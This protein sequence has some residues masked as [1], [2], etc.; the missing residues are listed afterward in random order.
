VA[1][2][3][4][5]LVAKRRDAPYRPGRPTTDWVVV[6]AVHVSPTPGRG[7]W[8]PMDALQLLQQDH[9]QVRALI[10]RFEQGDGDKKAAVTEIIAL[11]KVHNAIEE[12]IFYPAVRKEVEGAADAVAEGYEEH[13][14]AAKEAGEIESF[15]GDDEKW[16][17]KATV[18][19]ELFQHHAEEEEK[20]MFAKVREGMDASRRADLGR[21]MARRK[22]ALTLGALDKASLEKLAREHEI[23]GRS[24]MTK[25]ELAE[26]LADVDE[27]LTVG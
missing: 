11:L 7:S 23:A 6:P 9:D 21:E 5:G 16:E 18:L 26:A 10:E 24:N 20:E 2:G 1:N 25:A 19:T 22:A 4:R 13:H 15:S 8:Q 17:A 12:E 3:G 27:A 14:V